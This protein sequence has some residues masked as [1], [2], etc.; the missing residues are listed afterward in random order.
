MEGRQKPPPAKGAFPPSPKYRSVRENLT[1]FK[2]FL[3]FSGVFFAVSGVL[4]YANYR[5][6]SEPLRKLLNLKEPTAE[7]LMRKRERYTYREKMMGRRQLL[8]AMPMSDD[9]EEDMLW[10]RQPEMIE[11]EEELYKADIIPQ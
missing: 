1:V 9:E 6:T 7:S 11:N 4:F 8:S 3:R 5:W 2:S 10:F